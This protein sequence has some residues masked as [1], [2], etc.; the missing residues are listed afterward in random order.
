MNSKVKKDLLLEMVGILEKYNCISCTVAEKIKG[1]NVIRDQDIIYD[2]KRL[3]RSGMS[4]F[5]AKEKL[6]D[7]YFMSVKNI[8]KII[9]AA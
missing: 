2:Y 6:S 7:K 5:D 9:Y 4:A 1:L 8:E 3:R